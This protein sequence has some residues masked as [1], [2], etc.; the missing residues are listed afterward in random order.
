MEDF[1]QLN[2]ALLKAEAAEDEQKE[3]KRNTKDS[4]I[5]KI[6]KL[7]EEQD[8]PL[9]Y[10]NTKLRRMTKAELGK[11]LA[12]MLQVAARGHMARQVGADPETA[13][14]AT[15]ALGALRMV[16]D[17]AASATER[18]ANAVLPGYGYEMAG[19]CDNLKDPTVREATDACLAEIAQDTDVLQ[20]IESPWS[21]LGIAWL[22][23]MSMSVRRARPKPRVIGKRY[24]PH[25]PP[26]NLGPDPARAENTV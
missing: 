18:A 7:H 24:R 20:Y 25:E 4:L 15:I 21:R 17:I 26:P 22:G 1:A 3:P 5:S 8:V 16:H 12:D 10:S 19:F 14:D 9:M 6:V 13:T 11:V 2:D 23:A